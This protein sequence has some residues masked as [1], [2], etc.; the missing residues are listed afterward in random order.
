MHSTATA[1][2]GTCASRD[3]R[4]R[5]ISVAALFLQGSLSAVPTIA[6][7]SSY[8]LHQR[9]HSIQN[10]KMLATIS[11]EAKTERHFIAYM[12]ALEIVTTLS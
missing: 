3:E 10:A 7:C 11:T 12:P 8:S 1:S 2:V 5:D 4:G 6:L 9:Y